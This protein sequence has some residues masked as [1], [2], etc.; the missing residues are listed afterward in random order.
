MAR[1]D[2]VILLTG[3]NGALARKIAE[4]A[5]S[6]GEFAQVL[7]PGRE[8]LDVTEAAS[9]DAC[10]SGLSRLDL[11]VL[12]AGAA[13]DGPALRLS[14]ESWDR[15]MHANLKGAFLCAKAA[16]RLLSKSSAGHIVTIGSWSGLHGNAGQASYAAAKAGLI[17]LTKTLAQELAPKNIRVNCVLPGWLE[18]TKMTMAVNENAREKARQAHALG[19][20]NTLEDAAR[21]VLFLHTMEH[22]SG[23]I[24]QLDSRVGSWG[25]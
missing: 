9:V 16:F 5:Q 8:K 2:Q 10:F 11:L 6:G 19:R 21:F 25:G 12:N 14:S 20:F 15:V 1:T 24:F 17:G 23:Q 18:G 7:S 3:G 4:Q 22:V 13:E